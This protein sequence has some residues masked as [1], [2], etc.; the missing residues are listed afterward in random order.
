VTGGGCITYEIFFVNFWGHNFVSGLR[1]TGHLSLQSSGVG[2]WVPASAGKENAG[3]IH[4]V[5]GWTR[6]VQVK[7]WDPLKTRAIPE[8][9]SGVFTTRRYTNP[10]L[11]YL[12][13]YN[14]TLQI[15]F[16]HRDHYLMLLGQG[17][18][19]FWVVKN[20][21]NKIKTKHWLPVTHRIQYK[22]SLMM[23]LVHSH[24]CP[25]YMS[26]TVSMVSDDPGRRRSATSTDYH[27]PRTL[28]KL[29]DR[30]FSIAG[31]K[32]WNNLPQSVRSADSLDSFKRK[33]KFYLFNSCFNLWAVFVCVLL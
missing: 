16:M 4:S 9:L 33:L 1:I 32:A 20:P 11:P 10:R 5:S 26:N 25:D 12:P 22:L 6:G 30:A 13:Y 19:A 27:V 23:F 3:M 7:L 29:G 15:N 24:Q 17:R 18:R 14:T 2:K 21:R 8:R 28:T 31:P